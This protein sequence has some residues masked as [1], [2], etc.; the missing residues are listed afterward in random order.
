MKR[1]TS[2]VEKYVEDIKLDGKNVPDLVESIMRPSDPV[3]E[4]LRRIFVKL[5]RFRPE[6]T[7]I[8]VCTVQMSGK[9]TDSD[10]VATEALLLTPPHPLFE[11]FGR[12]SG[13]IFEKIRVLAPLGLVTLVGSVLTAAST[14]SNQRR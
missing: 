10:K 6:I 13:Q 2:V 8:R 7:K 9:I 5:H 11:I 12:A 1:H 3:K 14:P 4:K